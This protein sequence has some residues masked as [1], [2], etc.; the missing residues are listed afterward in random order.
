ME[1]FSS[2]SSFVFPRKNS[3]NFMAE[4]KT[5]DDEIKK[6]F[7]QISEEKHEKS[8][9]LIIGAK[10]S[11]RT[12]L[13]QTIWKK[14]CDIQRPFITLY[15]EDRVT[16][17]DY[18]RFFTSAQGGDLLMKTAVS[19]SEGMIDYIQNLS[20]LYFVRIIACS[21]ENDSSK[22]FEKLYPKII[23]I[24]PLKERREDIKLIVSSI[25]EKHDSLQITSEALELLER[26]PWHGGVKELVNTISYC[27]KLA[28][29]GNFTAISEPILEQALKLE[30]IENYDE[31]A[32]QFVM[33]SMLTTVKK[34]GLKDYIS[35]FES[36]C[37]ATMLKQCGGCSSHAAKLLKLHVNTLNSKMHGLK[38]QLKNVDLLLDIA[39]NG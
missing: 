5:Y 1:N 31:E 17:E 3:L 14:C 28:L 33:K 13:A 6:F 23:S 24:K 10:G 37:I 39:G 29:G 18:L 21:E 2:L 32:I 30:L 16:K 38:N 8:H 26:I 27:A 12:T 15:C 4:F 34:V 9:V 25:M 22:K 35:M 20:S 19:L 36:L 11:G 7:R